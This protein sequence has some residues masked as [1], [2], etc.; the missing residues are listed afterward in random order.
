MASF[1][2]PNRPYFNRPFYEN[3]NDEN[4]LESPFLKEGGEKLN[5]QA[6]KIK[7][8]EVNQ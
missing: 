3:A 6:S 5:T 7:T 8:E 4:T 1:K 2:K